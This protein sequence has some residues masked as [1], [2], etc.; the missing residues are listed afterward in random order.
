MLDLKLESTEFNPSFPL[1]LPPLPVVTVVG[2]GKG[3][4][5]RGVEESEEEDKAEMGAG[6]LEGLTDTLH[7]EGE[8]LLDLSK[9]TI[10]SLA[11]SLPLEELWEDPD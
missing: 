1:P 6:G 7:G 5:G 11:L 3:E 4:I 2:M 9:F 10:P 8:A